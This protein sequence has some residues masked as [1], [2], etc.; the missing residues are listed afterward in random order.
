MII[1]VDVFIIISSLKVLYII[2]LH[3]SFIE[4]SLFG[5]VCLPCPILVLPLLVDSEFTPKDPFFISVS[6]SL[7]AVSMVTSVS[8]FSA[9]MSG[10]SRNCHAIAQ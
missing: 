10:N 6:D 8:N 3:F 4:T 9:D 1:G 7:F 5:R 2:P